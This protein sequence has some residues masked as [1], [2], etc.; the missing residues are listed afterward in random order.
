MELPYLTEKAVT[1][2]IKHAVMEDIG[3]GDHS[4]LAVISKNEKSKAKLIT[5]EEGV[6]A[7]IQLAKRIFQYLD[8]NIGVTTYI[9][10][11]E[12]FNASDIILRVSG[13]AQGILSAERIVLNCLQRM[14]GIATYT[15]KLTEMIKGTNAKILDTR[16]TT[17]NFR[18]MEKWAVAIGGGKNHRLGL[19]DMIILKDNHIDFAGG[20]KN[21]V[22]LA[23]KYL[24]KN[25]K[26]LKVEVEARD[27]DEV[28]EAL[29]AGGVDMIMLDNMLLSEIREAV[30]VINGQ[31]L[32]EASGNINE[33]TL[34]EVAD[35]GV[36]FISVGALTHS[37]KII[38]MSLSAE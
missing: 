10:D 7:G 20:V 12:K 38:D 36:D 16:K 4:S 3:E 6:A 11:G 14:S 22:G 31:C 24:E 33:E 25:N 37:A 23:K 26:K 19:Y 17:P 15:R 32:T 9:E 35:C 21:A 28:K 8:P 27:L 13:P 34:R 5:R 29:E 18:I 1:Q 2:F 30:K